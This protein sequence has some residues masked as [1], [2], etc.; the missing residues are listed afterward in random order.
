[1]QS[2]FIVKTN[3]VLRLGWG[4]D[5]MNSFFNVIIIIHT[6]FLCCSEISATCYTIWPPKI[7]MVRRKVFI[8][9]KTWCGLRSHVYQGLESFCSSCV[10][11]SCN[12]TRCN[13][14]V[15]RVTKCCRSFTK[16]FRKVC[17]CMEI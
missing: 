3:L 7:K 9:L 15:A 2:H 17:A 14:F 10:M 12:K 5:N 8:S 6:K 11:S 4:F 13:R 16:Y 1:M